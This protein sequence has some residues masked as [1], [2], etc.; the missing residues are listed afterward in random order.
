M[1]R[2]GFALNITSSLV[3]GLIPMRAFVAGFR[4]TVIRM[5]PGSLNVPGPA[6]DRSALMMAP[7]TWKTPAT[8]R[9]GAPTEEELRS[10]LERHRGNVAA[11]GREL[12]KERMQVHRWMKRYGISVEEYRD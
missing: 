12:G 11:V 2:A 5:S 6:L 8:S 3:K 9:R 4:C 7:I 1:F 10:L